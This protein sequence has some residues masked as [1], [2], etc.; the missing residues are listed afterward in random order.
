VTAQSNH[1]RN[2]TALLSWA[3]SSPGW[4][5]DRARE[6]EDEVVRFARELRTRGIDVDLDLHHAAERGADWT[7]FGPRAV[8]DKDWVIVALSPG[9]RERWEG[10]NLPTSGAGAAAEADALLS[11]YHGEG[12]DKFREKLVLVTLPSM[13]GEDLVPTGLHGVHRFS[14]PEISLRGLEDLLRLLTNQPKHPAEPL[15]AIPDLPPAA[16]SPR[17]PRKLPVDSRATRLPSQDSTGEQSKLPAALQPIMRALSD[18]DGE[19]RYD[20]LSAL[21]DRLSS[22]LLPHIEPFLDD[23][24][25]YTRR[26]ALEYYAQLTGSSGTDRIVAALSDPDGEV[27]YDALS[28]LRDRLSSELLPHIEPFLDDRD[29]YTRR[30]A[31]EYYAQLTGS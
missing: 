30:L 17:P 24:D 6:W 12:Q 18:P 28:A 3:H 8:M 9:W 4:N 15:G 29:P 26:L 5:E 14:I 27:R 23:R 16:V 31:L 1:L 11:I 20:A 13:L 22:E 21:R 2:P 10:R 7:R 19:V 25:P